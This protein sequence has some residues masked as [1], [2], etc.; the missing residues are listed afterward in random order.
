MAMAGYF[1]FGKKTSSRKGSPDKSGAGKG[2]LPAKSGQSASKKDVGW[3]SAAVSVEPAR[4]EKRM[5]QANRQLDGVKRFIDSPGGAEAIA[6]RI[7]M[8]IAAGDKG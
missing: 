4:V 6:Q 2:G 8:M 7:R 3:G 1:G 5:A